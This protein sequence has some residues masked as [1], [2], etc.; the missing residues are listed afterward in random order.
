MVVAYLIKYVEKALV[1]LSVNGLQLYDSISGALQGER[2]E[3][4]GG[5][6]ITREQLPLI[7][8]GDGCQLTKVAYHHHLNSSKRQLVFAETTQHGIHSVEQVGS[9]HGNLVYHERIDRLYGESVLLFLCL[10]LSVGNKGRKR[11]LEE[12]VNGSALG[13][14]GSNTRR[15]HYDNALRRLLLQPAQKRSLTRTGFTGK[16]QV[17]IGCLYDVPREL[18]LFVHFHVMCIGL[19]CLSCFIEVQK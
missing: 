5:G 4:V 10:V 2:R 3:E 19:S 7:V 16:E 12:R 13:V 1:V 8:L 6:I 11:Q 18:R 17:C 15:S 14:D 9:H